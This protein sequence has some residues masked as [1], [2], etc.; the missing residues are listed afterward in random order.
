MEMADI[1]AGKR[2]HHYTETGSLLGRIIWGNNEILKRLG[3]VT[4][5]DIAVETKCGEAYEDAS[6]EPKAF[7]SWLNEVTP[8][9]VAIGEAVRESSS[10]WDHAQH[11]RTLQ[12]LREIGEH[13]LEAESRVKA[14]WA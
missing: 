3:L 10:E 11:Q 12:Y 13:A 2:V 1:V 4:L 5:Q 8:K 6:I 7:L 9:L 14:G